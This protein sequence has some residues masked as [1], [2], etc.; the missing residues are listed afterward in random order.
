MQV[1]QEGTGEINFVAFAALFGIKAQQ[2]DYAEAGRAEQLNQLSEARAAFKAFDLDKSDSIDVT[3]L[4]AD[5]EDHGQ[6]SDGTA[7]CV[8]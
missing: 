8:R 4:G 3:E 2:I 1:D 6:E 5:Y 7:S